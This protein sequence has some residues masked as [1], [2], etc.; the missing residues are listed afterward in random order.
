MAGRRPE[1]PDEDLA[2]IK[3]AARAAWQAKLRKREAR[4]FGFTRA[5]ALALAAGLLI[6]VGASWWWWIA[7][8]ATGPGPAARVETIAGMATMRTLGE[9]GREP[10]TTSVEVGQAIPAGTELDT[11]GADRGVPAQIALRLAGGSSLRIE[12]GSRVRIASLSVIELESGTVY[13]DSGAEPE[14]GAAVEVRTP[15]GV[16][17]DFGTQFEV[18]LLDGGATMRVRVR[19]GMVV[20][21]QGE[22]SHS[23]V[24]GME[25]TLHS[26]GSVVRRRVPA[27]GPEWRWVLDTAPHFDVEGRTLREFLDWVARETGWWIRFEDQAVETSAEA[28]IL[29]GAIGDLT[30]DQAPDVVLPGAGLSGRVVDGTL[31]ISAPASASGR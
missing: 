20:V 5:R 14:R 12:G 22:T 30:P 3:T 8:S 16:A 1:V 27:H 18:R 2:I 25:L 11:T 28:I 9:D 26:D 31:V 19:E 15:L 4:R 10:P 23:A 6:A 29:Y 17:A 24:D 13:V 21:E 7:R